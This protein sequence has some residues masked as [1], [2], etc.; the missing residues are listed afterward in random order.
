MKNGGWFTLGGLALVGGAAA[1]IAAVFSK[2][3]EAAGEVMD[4][5]GDG[6]FFNDFLNA[7]QAAGVPQEWADMPELLEIVRHESN[8]NTSAQNPGSSA[9][10]LFQMIKST[11]AQFLPEVAW[12]TADPYWQAVGGFRYIK[13][14]YGDPVRAWA[15]WQ[16]TANK[17]AS[18]AP[19]SLQATA[20]TWI[21]HGWV[22]Y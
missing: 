21:D 15:F 18:Q 6:P 10:G 12:G 9:Y 13:T 20:Q 17:D 8:F 2:A 16:A 1:V 14:R 19:S 3:K 11:W 7:T 5:I 22:G 4:R